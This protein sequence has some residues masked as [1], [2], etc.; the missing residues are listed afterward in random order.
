MGGYN[1]V[2]ADSTLSLKAAGLVAAS[3]AGSLIVDLGDGY[4][5]A[6]L[7]A[8]VSALEI[9][10][11]D[12]FYSLI[13]QGSPD[14]AFGTAGNIVE[15]AQFSLG[16]KGPR[17]S[18]AD[19]DDTTGVYDWPVHNRWN[20]TNYRYVRIYTKVAGTIAT[21]INYEAGLVVRA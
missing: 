15:L 10:S 21:G 7:L 11:G 8:K 12:E 6:V 16:A 4:S 3:A 5:K 20:G 1:A 17:L 14:A 18:D 2:V 13:L 19:K 9:A